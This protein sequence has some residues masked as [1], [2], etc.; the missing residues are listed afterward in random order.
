MAARRQIHPS[1][2]RI[3][4]GILLDAALDP[5]SQ[6]LNLARRAEE[7]NKGKENGFTSRSALSDLL[8]IARDGIDY[9]EDFP[10]KR[11][12]ELLLAWTYRW[13]TPADWKR[14][15]ARARKRRFYDR[16]RNSEP[17]TLKR[18]FITP[19]GS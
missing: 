3:W 10:P 17:T 2:H 14:L 6:Q 12:A 9:P 4:L 16:K 7:L 8:T 1:D 19:S 13:L 15:Q 18:D 11:T 5:T